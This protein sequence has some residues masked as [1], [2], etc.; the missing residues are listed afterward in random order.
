MKNGVK[1]VKSSDQIVDKAYCVIADQAAMDAFLSMEPPF[2]IGVVK[3][4]EKN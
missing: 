3:C 2:T 4:H 1:I